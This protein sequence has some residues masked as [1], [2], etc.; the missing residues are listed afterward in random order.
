MKMKSLSQSI[1]LKLTRRP[2]LLTY[3]SVIS[4][5]YSYLSRSSALYFYLRF[6]C[7]KVLLPSTASQWHLPSSRASQRLWWEQIYGSKLQQWQ[8]SSLLIC[9]GFFYL[10]QNVLIVS[11]FGCCLL[12]GCRANC[13]LNRNYFNPIVDNMV[14]YFCIWIQKKNYYD[15]SSAYIPW[16]PFDSFVAVLQSIRGCPAYQPRNTI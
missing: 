2:D 16:L 12:T 8:S 13:I 10:F 15:F 11:L 9:T 4:T 5:Y 6:L 7:Q 3:P 14:H 1:L